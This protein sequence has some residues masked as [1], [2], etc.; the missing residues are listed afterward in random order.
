MFFLLL[1]SL[2]GFSQFHL[3][4]F[5]GT[6]SYN[7][8]LN[9]KPFKRSKGAFGLSLNYEISDRFMLRSG[10][11]FGKVEGG[12][13]YSGSTFL[14]EN[15]NLSFQSAISE[16]NLMG[17]LTVFNLYNIRWSPY[18]FAGLALYHYNPYVKDSS[19]A[20]V[21]LRPLSTEGQGL[22][23]YPGKKPYALTQLAIPFGGGIKYNINDNIRLGLEIG[24]RKLSNDYLD[25]VSG[26]FVDEATLLVERGPKAVQ[27]AYRGDEVPG[28]HPLYPDNGYPAKGTQRGNIETKDWYYFTGLHLTFRL[29]GGYGKTDASGKKGRYGCP[30]V[31]M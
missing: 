23:A 20:K 1:L 14:K 15:R 12:D 25:D 6:T 31:P 17:E 30:T 16:F 13:Q 3:G 26:D 5:L 8:D 29:G 18:A 24:F 28:E 21:F 11:N 19:G 9:D 2:Q 22:T 4:V 27:Y 7:G 10:F